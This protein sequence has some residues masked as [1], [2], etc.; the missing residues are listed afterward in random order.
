MRSAGTT[1][2]FASSTASKVSCNFCFIQIRKK[3][4]KFDNWTAIFLSL[5]KKKLRMDA[6]LGQE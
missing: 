5:S 3:G 6:N 2:K 1:A 4:Q